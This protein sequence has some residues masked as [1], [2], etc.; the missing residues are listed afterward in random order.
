MEKKFPPLTME[1]VY[2]QYDRL[3]HLIAEKWMRSLGR[4]Y[5]LED[6]VQIVYVDLAE[7]I[8]EYDRIHS[9]TTFIAKYGKTALQSVW[10]EHHTLKRKPP[11]M[12]STAELEGILKSK[13]KTPLERSIERELPYLRRVVKSAIQRLPPEKQEII[14][15]RMKGRTSIEI[16]RQMGLKAKHVQHVIQIAMPR[17]ADR[18]RKTLPEAHDILEKR[19]KVRRKSKKV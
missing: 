15:K 10:Y 1:M 19:K 6:L 8:H 5:E 7:K 18:I 16:A 17:I 14:R 4:Y 3:I 2:Q 13:Q 12:V 9:P 11:G